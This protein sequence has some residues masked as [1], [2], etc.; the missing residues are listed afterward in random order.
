MK[1]LDCE[2]C[3]HA[4]RKM[5]AFTIENVTRRWLLEL[6]KNRCN[7]EESQNSCKDDDENETSEAI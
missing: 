2:A 5:N 7:H 3:T 4:L 1:S 6:L